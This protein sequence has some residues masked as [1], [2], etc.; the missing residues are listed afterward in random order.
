MMQHIVCFSFSVYVL[1]PP[2]GKQKRQPIRPALGRIAVLD[3][4]CHLNYRSRNNG[5]RSLF[6]TRSPLKRCR[7][8]ARPAA[9]PTF[10]ISGCSSWVFFRVLSPSRLAPDA[11]L[12]ARFLRGTFPLQRFYWLKNST[13]GGWCQ[14]LILQF[15]PF[16]ILHSFFVVPQFLQGFGMILADIHRAKFHTMERV[17]IQ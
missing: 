4:R 7:C 16:G 5:I 14:G 11:R 3:P 15:L 12:S 10:F 2:N 17:S 8:N 13:I 1:H 6:R 9:R